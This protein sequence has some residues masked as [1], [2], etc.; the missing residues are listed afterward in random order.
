MNRDAF[1]NAAI[2]ATNVVLVIA[3]CHVGWAHWSAYEL[4]KALERRD[5][6]A[7][8]RRVDW[9]SLRTNLKETLAASMLNEF[10]RSAAAS[11]DTSK[12]ATGLAA[13]LGPAV[14][15]GMV[16]A[17]VTPQGVE[18]LFNS[19]TAADAHPAVR[20]RDGQ[21]RRMALVAPTRF[22]IEL[23]DPQEERGEIV[24]VLEMVGLSWK[25][26]GLVPLKPFSGM[27]PTTDTKDIAT[28]STRTS[29]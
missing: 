21:V 3:G 28:G 25:V 27:G 2:W 4:G 19:H 7:L 15:N 1:V 9:P 14:I 22:E 13:I 11:T 16:D 20:L 26:T 17:Y 5:A 18:V 24:A 6:V 10:T 8:G 12:A 23:G 29:R